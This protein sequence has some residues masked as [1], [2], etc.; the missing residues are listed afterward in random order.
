[1]LAVGLIAAGCAASAR[2]GSLPTS[3]TPVATSTTASTTTLPPSTTTTVV[4][5]PST[6][7]PLA[8]PKGALRVGVRSYDWID[9]SR[10]TPANGNYRARNQREIMTTIWYPA[11]GTPSAYTH[12]GATPDHTHGPFPIVLF[13]HGHGGEPDDYTGLVSNLA[14]R[15][16]V[17]VAPAFPLSRRTARGGPTYSDILD[18]PGDLSFA[19][20]R[21]LAGNVEPGSWMYHLVD[22]RR[23]AAVGHSMGAWTVLGLVGNA[24]C[25]DRR[26][27]A[28]ISLAGELAPEFPPKFFGRGTPPILFV[29]GR[30]DDIVPY[31]AGARAYAAAR[32]P[33][34][35]LTV[36]SGGH[37]VPYRG[38][39][40]PVGATVMQVTNEFLDRYVRGIKTVTPASPDRRYATLQRRL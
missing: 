27:I 32:R 12:W 37:V 10:A 2:A 22:V 39:R 35:F 7:P 17:V 3:T 40:T 14:S 23:V 24:C 15:G 20:D 30:D 21:V 36:T 25:H 13:A 38:P 33:K 5:T 16:Y 9:W 6:L 1:L 29:N 11:L 26:V 19:L 31:A 8:A 28:A 34:Y 18:Q 4:A